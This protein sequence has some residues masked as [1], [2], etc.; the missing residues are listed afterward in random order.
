MKENKIIIGN[1]KDGRNK[2]KRNI[3]EEHQ[4]KTKP[5]IE[6]NDLAIEL[7]QIDEKL[8][9]NDG[10]IEKKLDEQFLADRRLFVRVRYFQQ[11]ECSVRYEAA[12]GDPV[13]LA[14]PIKLSI[15]DISAGGIGAICDHEIDIGTI[16]PLKLVLDDISYEIKYKVVY[17]IA[18]DDKFRIGLKI[19]QKDKTFARHLKI[20]VAKLSLHVKDNRK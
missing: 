9:G 17:C 7:E 20:Y 5:I 11:I 10:E 12:D 14:E 13:P 6:E 15:I 1:S 18:N 2:N 16:L 8:W 4:N 19:V 3:Q